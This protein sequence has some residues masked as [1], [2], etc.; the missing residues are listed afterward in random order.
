MKKASRPKRNSQGKLHKLLAGWRRISGVGRGLILLGASL[1]LLAGVCVGVYHGMIQKLDTNA[2]NALSIG[3]D[4]TEKWKA[5]TRTQ[6]IKEI[7]P[8]TQEEIE[9]EIEVP[10]IFGGIVREFFHRAPVRLG[11]PSRAL[12]PVYESGDLAHLQYLILLR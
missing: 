7:D 11:R 4:A 8:E 6:I 2:Q 3:D 10:E 1:C 5:P 12:C 9:V